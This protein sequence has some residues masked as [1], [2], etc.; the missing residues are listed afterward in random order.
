MVKL[1]HFLSLSFV[2]VGRGEPSLSAFT[3]MRATNTC[4]VC[5]SD[6]RVRSPADFN[7]HT[8]SFVFAVGQVPISAQLVLHNKHNLFM[9]PDLISLRLVPLSRRTKSID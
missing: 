3:F 4:A 9:Y 6:A 7:F 8:R 2:E 1:R 5:S